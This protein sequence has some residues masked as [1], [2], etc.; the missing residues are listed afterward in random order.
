[1]WGK[2]Y[3]I[4]VILLLFVFPAAAVLIEHVTGAGPVMLLVG[5][6]F[7]FFAVGVRLFMAGIRQ[8]LQP[9]FTAEKIFGVT[10]S[11]SH[12]IVREVGFGNLS[13]GAAGLISLIAP[14]W[15]PAVAFTGGLYYGLAGV[16]HVINKAHTSKEAIA[17]WSDLFIFVVLAAYFV[18]SLS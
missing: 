12:P 17:L 5:K 9:A 14:G 8:S 10:D 11:A 2:M 16:G 7:T 3:F 1:M 15:L 18:S 4:T 6:W 13:M